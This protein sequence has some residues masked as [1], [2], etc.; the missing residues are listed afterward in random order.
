VSVRYGNLP[1]L[2]EAVTTRNKCDACEHVFQAGDVAH[3]RRESVGSGVIGG[4]RWKLQAFC[5]ACVSKWP[6]SWL[7]SRS[8]PELCLGGCGVFVSHWNFLRDTWDERYNRDRRPKTCSYRCSEIVAKSR[9]RVAEVEKK[10]ETCDESFTPM[11]RDGR[12][13]SNACRQD[14]YRKRKLGAA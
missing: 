3:R 14:A 10:C 11:R 8:T 5:E 9:R 2:P 13:C 7:R 12:F 6:P 1:V 4:G